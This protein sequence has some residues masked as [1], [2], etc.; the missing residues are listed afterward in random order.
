[1]QNKHSFME[2]STAVFGICGILGTIATIVFGIYGIFD[3]DSSITVWAVLP[4][5]SITNLLV[6]VTAFLFM[7]NYYEQK[8]EIAK[9]KRI[10]LSQEDFVKPVPSGFHDF[11][12]ASRDVAISML[13]GTGIFTQAVQQ[14]V[15]QLKSVDDSSFKNYQEI[16]YQLTNEF[17]EYLKGAL[18]TIAGV[19]THLTGSE[20]AVTIKTIGKHIHKQYKRIGSVA[21]PADYSA[22]NDAAICTFMRNFRSER[23]RKERDEKWPFF[24]YYEVSSFKQIFEHKARSFLSND[25]NNDKRYFCKYS[26]EDETRPYNASLVVPM[27]C[28]RVEDRL[29]DERGYVWF[30]FLCVDNLDGGFQDSYSENMLC[31]FADTLYFMLLLW[32]DVESSYQ[33]IKNKRQEMK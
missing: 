29:S 11:S 23:G 33:Q 22:A 2:I 17:T 5:L 25:L 1:M 13:L 30:G 18:D 28:L 24:P 27:R 32:D 3:V 21:P 6:V 20:C 31:S 12:H 10:E 19:F 9:A 26:M 8:R 14:A 15:E 4:V 7:R 16:Y